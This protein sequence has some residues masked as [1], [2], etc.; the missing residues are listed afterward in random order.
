MELREKTA[1]NFMQYI[2]L[3]DRSKQPCGE[4]GSMEDWGRNNNHILNLDINSDG[5][6]QTRKGDLSLPEMR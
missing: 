6:T 5:E 2:F 4:T 3:N 1:F